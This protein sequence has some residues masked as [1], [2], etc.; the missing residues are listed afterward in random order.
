MKRN[1]F[2]ALGLILI[3]SFFFFF[4][5]NMLNLIA[6]N[7]KYVV[8]I[9]IILLASFFVVAENLGLFHNTSKNALL[10][11]IKHK[12]ISVGMSLLVCIAI[13]TLV[14][15]SSLEKLQDSLKNNCKKTE[16]IYSII[17]VHPKDVFTTGTD[18]IY[19]EVKKEFIERKDF[20][21]EIQIDILGYT[22]YSVEPKLKTWY[23]EGYL[24]NVTINLLYINPEFIKKTEFL[25]EVWEQRVIDHVS[26]IRLFSK[27]HFDEFNKKNIKINLIPYNH[28]PG[29]HGFRFRNGRYFISFSTWNKEGKIKLPTED[30]YFIVKPNEQTDH[31]NTL[32]KLMD[33]WIDTKLNHKSPNR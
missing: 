26:Q 10:K 25:D 29:V 18:G 23:S 3:F 13:M 22:L 8:M 9:I 7:W 5:T 33:N 6:E 31:G 19:E 21:N 16:E 15:N 32:R 28:I 1:L 14:I 30:S 11:F 27:Q 2:I 4:G 17:G 12:E 20:E 24:N